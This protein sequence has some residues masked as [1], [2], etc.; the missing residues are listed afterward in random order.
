MEDKKNI[1]AAQPPPAPYARDSTFEIVSSFLNRPD[2][3]SQE[4]LRLQTYL[5]DTLIYTAPGTDKESLIATAAEVYH[6]QILLNRKIGRTCFVETKTDDAL[7][8]YVHNEMALRIP[9]MRDIPLNAQFSQRVMAVYRETYIGET[10]ADPVKIQQLQNLRD[11]LNNNPNATYD[12]ANAVLHGA[13]SPPDIS[14]KK[15]ISNRFL[16]NKFD[17]ACPDKKR[18][19]SIDSINQFYK[20]TEMTQKVSFLKDIP[21]EKDMLYIICIAL[22]FHF[23]DF[24]KLRSIIQKEKQD[25]ALCA[26]NHLNQRD[27]LIQSVLHHI[28]KWYETVS[29]EENHPL[30]EWMPQLVL[31]RVDRMLEEK[32]LAPLYSPRRTRHQKTKVSTSG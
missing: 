1:P 16:E 23:D 27:Q 21:T 13:W 18:L 14:F 3:I 2:S 10:P 24:C 17:P 26:D 8:Y 5:Y 30:I 29:A 4:V 31:L 25:S 6:Y 19:S 32:G 12:G 28:D 20:Q 11:Y 7:L 9:Q 15:Y 22:G